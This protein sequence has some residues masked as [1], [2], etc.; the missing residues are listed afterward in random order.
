MRCSQEKIGKAYNRSQ[1]LV[2]QSRLEEIYGNLGYADMQVR[3]EEKRLPAP[4]GILHQAVIASGDNVTISD[5]QIRGN[6]KTKPDFIR[7]RIK[8]RSRGSL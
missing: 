4:D 3:L 7:R 5:V 8:F 1:R 6:I 2:V